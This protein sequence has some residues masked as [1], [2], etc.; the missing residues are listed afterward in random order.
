[1]YTEGSLLSFVRQENEE[2]K[3]RVM[4]S[5]HCL[6][7][8]MYFVLLNKLMISTISRELQFQL[9]QA[10]NNIFYHDTNYT[11]LYCFHGMSQI[12]FMGIT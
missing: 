8:S 1:M 4:L 3:V 9:D 10:I 5:C 7:R 11:S 6:Y 12:Y 2:L